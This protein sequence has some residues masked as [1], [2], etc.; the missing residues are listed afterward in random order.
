[1]LKLGDE[2][3]TTGRTT[4]LDRLPAD[5]EA[6]SK[7]YVKVRP[8][9]L[10]TTVLAQLDTGSPWSVLDPEIADAAGLFGLPGEPKKLLGRGIIF[11]GHLIRVPILILAD[12]GD[13]LEVDAVVFVSKDWPAGNFVGYAGLLESI[14]VALDPQAN[15]F[16]FGAGQR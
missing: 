15:H 6:T 2:D 13:S 5:P 11:D 1:M 4:F 9:D 7:I 8:G 14:R 10:P 3:F 12:E 16:Y